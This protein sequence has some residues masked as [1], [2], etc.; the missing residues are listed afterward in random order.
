L[1]PQLVAMAN[2][3]RSWGLAEVMPVI[4]GRSCFK[5]HSKAVLHRDSGV[6]RAYEALLLSFKLPLWDAPEDYA[7]LSRPNSEPFLL[8]GE[9]TY[10]PQLSEIGTGFA[11]KRRSSSV[12]STDGSNESA[13]VF[14]YMHNQNQSSAALATA[15]T[16]AHGQVS[17]AAAAH[18]VVSP[19][20][21]K[22]RQRREGAREE[23][24]TNLRSSRSSDQF[25]K[26]LL[27]SPTGSDATQQ[28]NASRGGAMDPASPILAPTLTRAVT[29]DG[30][31]AAPAAPRAFSQAATARSRS[32][33]RGNSFGAPDRQSSGLQ[34]VFSV[35]FGQSVAPSNSDVRAQRGM[36]TS[37][38]APQVPVSRTEDTGRSAVQDVTGAR[39]ESSTAVTSTSAL[40]IPE[41]I[42]ASSG[43]ALPRDEGRSGEVVENALSSSFPP[44]N[45]G[46]LTFSAANRDLG[47][48]QVVNLAEVGNVN[49]P[50]M[51]SPLPG[52][53][54]DYSAVGSTAR[55]PYTIDDTPAEDVVPVVH[56]L[57]VADN[58]PAQYS[59]PVVMAAF[60]GARVLQEVIQVLPA[61]LRD[62]AVDIVVFLLR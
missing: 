19:A 52:E 29:G 55:S 3:L 41:S 21:S 26:G 60:D 45:L 10:D 53:A 39:G 43:S 38:T 17:G 40:A 62:F 15:G 34:S 57:D 23:L 13:K 44:S 5:V 49:A 35:F 18:Y 46:S 27:L 33:E 32:R 25:L 48:R 1:L 37:G 61:P 58:I 50:L 4:Y 47:F 8:T 22:Y 20:I 36:S 7:A 14:Q 59:L 24:Q 2:Y 16:P 31:D 12:A 56:N 9:P 51:R 11:S 28:G 54:G 42:R 6:G 30:T